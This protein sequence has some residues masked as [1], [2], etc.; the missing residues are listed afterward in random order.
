MLACV[1]N[2]V[3][4]LAA[5]YQ[6]LFS[7]Q[8]AQSAARMAELQQELAQAKAAQRAAEATAMQ[9]ATMLAVY[10]KLQSCHDKAAQSSDMYC[11]VS[12]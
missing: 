6:Q 4:Q 2:R 3:A 9:Q 1:E 10:R 11:S 7:E 8:A 12:T 5:T